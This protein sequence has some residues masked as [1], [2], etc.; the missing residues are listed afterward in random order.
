MATNQVLQ[1]PKTPT[2]PSFS[3]PLSGLIKY[4][5]LES[6]NAPPQ[7][8]AFPQKWRSVENHATGLGTRW[9]FDSGEVIVSLIGCVT[10][11]TNLCKGKPK[12]R[13]VTSYQTVT[14]KMPLLCHFLLNEVGRMMFRHF[15]TPILILEH[16]SLHILDA[17]TRGFQ[18]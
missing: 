9:C 2:D 11:L 1:R 14:C 4:L 5:L 18:Q 7:K 12:C 13:V 15:Q 6:F 3:T 16:G 10:L 17:T 8:V